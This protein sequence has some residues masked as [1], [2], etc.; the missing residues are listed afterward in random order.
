MLANRLMVIE[1]TRDF[2]VRHGRFVLR[3]NSNV[4]RQ[5]HDALHTLDDVTYYSSTVFQLSTHDKYEV[6]DHASGAVV[7]SALGGP[8]VAGRAIGPADALTPSIVIRDR[9]WR[10]VFNGSTDAVGANLTLN[11]QTS[12]IVGVAGFRLDIPSGKTDIWDSAGRIRTGPQLPVLRRAAPRQAEARRKWC[13]QRWRHRTQS[14]S[15][16]NSS[17]WCCTSLFHSARLT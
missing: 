12:T 7:L 2:K 11:G 5:W 3:S 1:A 8:M 10:R 9:L 4:S 14:P 17:S 15:L 13:S 6:I 16:E